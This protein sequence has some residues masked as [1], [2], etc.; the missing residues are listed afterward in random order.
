M[1]TRRAVQQLVYRQDNQIIRAGFCAGKRD[2]PLLHRIQKRCQVHTTFYPITTAGSF[3]GIKWS[4]KLTT[5][6]HLQPRKRI[7]GSIHPLPRCLICIV[8][9]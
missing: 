5:H 9:N 6:H 7:C 1:G 3:Y 8:P 2:F 4:I